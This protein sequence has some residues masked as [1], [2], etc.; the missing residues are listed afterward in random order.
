MGDSTGGPGGTSTTLT[1]APC[2]ADGL[3]RR[4]HARGDG[5]ALLAAVVLVHQVDLHVAHSPPA[6]R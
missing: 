3:Q 5:V 6:R 2:A 1:L 4:A